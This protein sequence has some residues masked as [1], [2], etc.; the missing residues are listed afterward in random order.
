VCPP[1]AW[2]QI[3]LRDT[4]VSSQHVGI[5]HQIFSWDQYDDDAEVGFVI[6][7][8]EDIEEVG[9]RGIVRRIR[10]VVGTNPVYISLDIDVLDPGTAPACAVPLACCRSR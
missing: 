6:S 7:H 8:A 9:W 4:Y 3:L 2:S 5:R 1:T 10:D